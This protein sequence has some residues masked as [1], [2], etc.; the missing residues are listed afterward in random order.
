MALDTDSNVWVFLTWSYPLRIVSSRFDKSS[1]ASRIKQ[2]ECGGLFCAT[3]A[4]SG[5]VHH[6]RH[7]RETYLGLKSDQV[8]A[9]MIENGAIP[10]TPQLRTL[11]PQALP[12]LP[13]LPPINLPSVG[14]VENVNPPKIVKIAGMRRSLL[15]L[16]DAGHV[17]QYDLPGLDVL[18]VMR[19]GRWTYVSLFVTLVIIYAF[20]YLLQAYEF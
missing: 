15:C 7:I 9:T 17:L 11:E 12:P 14:G 4:E 19:H 10:C 5:D 16:T 3:L 13:S 8:G 2:V 1:P 18:H 20:P 6:W